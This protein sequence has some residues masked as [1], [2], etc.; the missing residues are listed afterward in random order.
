MDLKTTLLLK[1]AELTPVEALINSLGRACA[2]YDE[3][4]NE[5]NQEYVIFISQ[6]L[7]VK[8]VM[9]KKGFDST[10]LAKDLEKHENIMNLFNTT[11]N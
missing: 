11:N 1:T 6:I 9:D 10:D 8:R 2:D 5:E 3:E 7:M 4:P